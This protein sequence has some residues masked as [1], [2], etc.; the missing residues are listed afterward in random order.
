MGFTPEAKAVW[1]EY[2]NMLEGQLGVGGEL[3]AVG[4]IVSKSAENMARLSALLTVYEHGLGGAIDVA[5]TEAAAQLALWYLTESRRFFGELALTESELDTTRLN[6]WLLTWCK[7]N[8]VASIS[9][10]DMQRMG[11]LRDKKRLDAAID[12]LTAHARVRLVKDG[13]RRMIE[14]NPALLTG[15]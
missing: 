5:E 13:K 12:Q 4:D 15:G 9:T 10:R 6:D 3:A 1:V 11:P 2:F 8:S 14:V 7:R